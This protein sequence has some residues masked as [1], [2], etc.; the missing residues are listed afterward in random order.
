MPDTEARMQ[1]SEA[2]TPGTGAGIRPKGCA[3]ISDGARRNPVCQP[4][5]RNLPCSS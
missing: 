5:R 1:D 3:N 4:C 2:R